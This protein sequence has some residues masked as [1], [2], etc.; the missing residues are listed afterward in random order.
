MADNLGV[1]VA[2]AKISIT[3]DEK[4]YE[5]DYSWNYDINGPQARGFIRVWKGSE[6]YY[7]PLERIRVVLTRNSR[8]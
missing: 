3:T 1:V 5:F 6:T 4:S 7:F 2:K 8:N